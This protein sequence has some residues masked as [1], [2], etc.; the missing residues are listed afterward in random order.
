MIGERIRM[1]AFKR[2][3]SGSPLA[4]SIE[5]YVFLNARSEFKFVRGVYLAGC[6]IEHSGKWS[7]NRQAANSFPGAGRGDCPQVNHHIGA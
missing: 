2:G 4:V 5:A 1:S 6:A 3:P 7:A